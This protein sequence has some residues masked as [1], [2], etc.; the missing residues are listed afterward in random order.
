MTV[1][2][3]SKSFLH[4]LAVDQFFHRTLF[5]ALWGI[6]WN[7]NSPSVESSFPCYSIINNRGTKEWV[8]RTTI[9]AGWTKESPYYWR[10]RTTLRIK[11][12]S[13]D[14]IPSSTWFTPH[15][16]CHAL[17]SC[18]VCRHSKPIVLRLWSPESN[19][20]SL[21]LLSCACLAS[22]FCVPFIHLLWPR[23]LQTTPSLRSSPL[24]KAW[25]LPVFWFW[26]GWK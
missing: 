14:L 26:N 17:C 6:S 9:G 16:T 24:K 25:P 7:S 23:R 4:D 5:T 15:N 11:H 22:S 19:A 12:Q 20:V 13:Q 2:L 3:I 10:F 8:P 1:F 21:P 18:Y